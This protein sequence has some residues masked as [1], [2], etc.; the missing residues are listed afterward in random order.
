MVVGPAAERP[1]VFAVRLGDRKF[2]DAGVAMRH[3]PVVVSNSQF[4]LP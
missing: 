2:V 4:S 3:Q 1:V